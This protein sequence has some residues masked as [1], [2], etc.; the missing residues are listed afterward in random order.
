MKA[1]IFEGERVF[2][3]LKSNNIK[4]RYAYQLIRLAHY[5]QDYSM[6]LEL[7]DRL[8]PRIDPVESIIYDWILSHKAGALFRLGKRVEA[9]Y[10]FSLV[11][12]RCPSK[13]EAAYQSFS[14][15]SEQELSLIHI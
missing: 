14:I 2:I 1:L 11:Y 6:V 15:R 8:L 13:R 3:K 7:Y 10:L 4:L 12:D 9:A 5:A